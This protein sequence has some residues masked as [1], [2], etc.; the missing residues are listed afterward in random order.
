M[1]GQL[2]FVFEIKMELKFI[3]VNLSGRFRTFN[4]FL[5]PGPD[6]KR[7]FLAGQG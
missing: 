2:S 1:E 3:Q 4:H 7:G 5:R 6:L